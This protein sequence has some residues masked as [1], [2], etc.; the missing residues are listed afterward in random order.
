MSN[1]KIS[2]IIGARA[3]SQRVKNKNTRLLN[4]KPLLVYTIEQ[5]IAL[6]KISD[7]F[8]SSN[9][10]EV[11]EICSDFD[12]VTF[13]QRP[14]NISTHVSKDIEYINHILESFSFEIFIKLNPTS[15]F[16]EVS[17]IERNLEKFLSNDKF[18]SARAVQLCKEHPGKMW[19]IDNDDLLKPLDLDLKF[20]YEMHEAQYQD[21]PKVYIQTSSL[22]IANVEKISRYNN[23]S[24]KTVM[25][26]LCDGVNSFSIDYEFE[27]DIAEKYL[28]GEI[29]LL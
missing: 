25:P 23:R 18:D 14:D 10:P 27:F 2:V 4:G 15:P 28:S 13:V 22:E 11:K 19:T 3:G 26:I 20:K 1:E 21:L 5:A 7:I 29:N 12:E 17:F 8:V 9:D 24:G 6:T 16:R